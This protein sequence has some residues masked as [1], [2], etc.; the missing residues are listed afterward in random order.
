[1]A[2]GRRLRSDRLEGRR[3]RKGPLGRRGYHQRRSFSGDKQLN[4]HSELPFFFRTDYW[5]VDG[6]DVTFMPTHVR[7]NASGAVMVMMMI[8]RVRMKQRRT[9][10]GHLHRNGDETRENG[11]EHWPSLFASP[12]GPSS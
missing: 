1:V 2:Y 5:A 9:E 11:P 12:A 10:G 6:R 8:I 4:R 3:E 7:M